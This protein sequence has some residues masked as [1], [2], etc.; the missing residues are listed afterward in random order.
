MKKHDDHTYLY[1]DGTVKSYNKMRESRR[2]KNDHEHGRMAKEERIRTV[3]LQG[4]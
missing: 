3:Q 1:L 2:R 4:T